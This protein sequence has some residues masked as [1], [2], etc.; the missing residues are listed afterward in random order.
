MAGAVVVIIDLWLSHKTLKKETK[1]ILFFTGAPDLAR[2]A[3]I[4]QEMGELLTRPRGH[5]YR[6]KVIIIDLRV[7]IIDLRLVS[8][9]R[10]KYDRKSI[11]FEK[12]T[13]P[14]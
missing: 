9:T 2:E 5:N 14:T 12:R 13:V 11:L 7:I 1:N 10:V 8:Q 4:S 3:W 6:L